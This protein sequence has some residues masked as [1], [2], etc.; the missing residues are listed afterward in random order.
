MTMTTHQYLNPWHEAGRYG[1]KYYTTEATPR[2]Y[3]GYL[4]FNRIPG[5]CWDIVKDGVCIA[6]RARMKG[7]RGFIDQLNAPTADLTE[8]QAY[9][10]KR[11]LKNLPPKP[12]VEATTAGLQYIIPG[13]EKRQRP[14]AT[15]LELLL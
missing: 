1:P 4:I 12:T 7:A 6:Q 11:A 3:G 9:F 8:A 2:E 15:Q 14:N 5:V 13:A 10:V